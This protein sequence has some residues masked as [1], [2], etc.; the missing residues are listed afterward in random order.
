LILLVAS[1][2]YRIASQS[3]FIEREAE[4]DFLHFRIWMKL[5]KLI[6]LALDQFYLFLGQGKEPAE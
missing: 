2:P 3:R 4:L 1:L 5:V 6:Q